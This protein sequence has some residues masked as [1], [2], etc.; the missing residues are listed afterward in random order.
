MLRRRYVFGVED[1][2]LKPLKAVEINQTLR[3]MTEKYLERDQARQRE[4]QY[5]ARIV[6]DAKKLHEQFMAGLLAADGF[7]RPRLSL[8]QINHDFEL[9]FTAAS[10]QAF[11]VKAEVNYESLNAN[12]RKLLLEKCMG[13][14]KETLSTKCH[15]LLL[16][17]TERGIYGIANFSENQ[18]KSLRRA[19]QLVI[20]VLQSQSEL[21]D[22]IKVSV[23]PGASIRRHQ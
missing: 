3:K 2:L 6:N 13:V 7:N 20:D 18:A 23:G 16:Y 17:P 14:I 10:F 12:V 19:M 11:V 22:R 8:E 4:A 5:T 1:Y 21:F 9:A 15:V